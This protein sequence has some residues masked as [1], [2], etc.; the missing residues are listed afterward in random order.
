MEH[1][2]LS[3]DHPAAALHAR[4]LVESTQ[5]PPWSAADRAANYPTLAELLR[6]GAPASSIVSLCQ[7]GGALSPMED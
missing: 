3:P 4:A 5:L 7:S 1:P 2:P 6:S